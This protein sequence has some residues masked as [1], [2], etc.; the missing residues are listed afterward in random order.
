M[1]L[2]KS[3]HENDDMTKALLSACACSLY[4]SNI[5][6]KFFVFTGEGRNGKSTIEDLLKYT[7]GDYYDSINPAQLTSYAREA[8]RANSELAKL[9]Y[10]RCVMTGEPESSDKQD[11]L[12]ISVIKRWTG[13]DPITTRAL[14]K[15]SF[16]FTPQFTLYLLCND[17]PR[18]SDTDGGIAE[19]MRIIPFPFKFT[20][21]EGK[22]LDE[23]QR[24]GDL[25]LKEKIRQDAYKYGFL[26]LLI[27]TWVETQGKFYE[28]NTIKSQTSLYFEELNV[29]KGWFEENYEVDE[30]GRVK[31]SQMF[32]EYKFINKD[33]TQKQFSKSM[34]DLCKSIKSHGTMAYMCKSKNTNDELMIEK[35]L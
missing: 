22:T 35:D 15:N 18:L 1:K 28:N 10:S 31:L 5:N 16:T 17:I 21:V 9:Q 33:I 25:N 12:K 6:E 19:R 34:K 23:N 2:V 3:L 29:V 24:V 4:G 11:T 8:D 13:R 20:G 30:T 32:S 14:N 26:H 7:L 27:D